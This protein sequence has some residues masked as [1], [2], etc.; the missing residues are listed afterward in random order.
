M[1]SSG[2][3]V[4]LGSTPFPSFDR[5]YSG[6]K[7]ALVVQKAICLDFNICHH[8]L[9][10]AGRS[11]VRLRGPF[12]GRDDSALVRW[13]TCGCSCRRASFFRHCNLESRSSAHYSDV[14]WTRCSRLMGS[15]Y[16]SSLGGHASLQLRPCVLLP[17]PSAMYTQTMSL[18]GM[19]SKK[20]TD[21]NNCRRVLLRSF[22]GLG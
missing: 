1:N 14:G 16:R 7:G 5:G 6:R 20:H 12:I 15:S 8:A 2:Y 18:G 3:E 21:G 4:G 22:V 11:S 13:S 19:S 9:G 10:A 17:L